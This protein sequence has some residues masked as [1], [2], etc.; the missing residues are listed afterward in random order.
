MNVYYGNQSSQV[1][2]GRLLVNL[3]YTIKLSP[4]TNLISHFIENVISEIVTMR[5]HHDEIPPG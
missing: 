1:T 4:S 5:P 3:S 2:A